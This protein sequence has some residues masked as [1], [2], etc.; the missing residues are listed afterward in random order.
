MSQWNLD[1]FG[2]NGVVQKLEKK[3]EFA[4]ISGISVLRHV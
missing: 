1:T 4:T 3:Y 2:M